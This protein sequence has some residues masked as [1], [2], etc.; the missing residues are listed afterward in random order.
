MEDGAAAKLQECLLVGQDT[1]DSRFKLAND[2]FRVLMADAHEIFAADILYPKNV[3][4]L[5][6]HKSEKKRYSQEET[7]ILNKQKEYGVYVMKRFLEL[8]CKKVLI[9]RNVYLMTELLMQ[10]IH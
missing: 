2:R 10:D 9:D 4:L 8:F 7:K 6:W 1:G 5:I 3:I